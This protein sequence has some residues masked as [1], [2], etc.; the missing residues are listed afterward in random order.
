MKKII[1]LLLLLF[2]GCSMPLMNY[3]P[4]TV[5]KVDSFISI[6][7]NSVEFVEVGGI[8]HN[9]NSNKNIEI[10]FSYEN[11]VY[12]KSDNTIIIYLI[13]LP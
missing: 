6:D 7:S 1:L 13:N 3:N 10:V 4:G 12:H 8:V 11:E 9:L 2:V 5:Y